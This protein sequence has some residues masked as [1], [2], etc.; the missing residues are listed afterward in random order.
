[1]A[2]IRHAEPK[3]TGDVQS[4]LL[5]SFIGYGVAMGAIFPVFTRYFVDWKPG[6]MGWF[7]ISCLLA[8]VL[9]G[10]LNYRLMNNFLRAR[11]GRIHTVVRAIGEGDFSQRC[12][13]HAHG[14]I[15]EI[16]ASIN[17]MAQR[18]SVSIGEIAQ[19]ALQ[20]SEGAQH[21][22]EIMKTSDTSL[23][24]QRAETAQLSAAINELASSIQQVAV[25][26]TQ[27]AEAAH[28]ANEDTVSGQKIVY[29]T[30]QS[31]NHLAEEVEKTAQ[32]IKRLELDSEKI[33][34]VL[35]V[36][37]SITEQT[38]L[39]ALNAAIEAARAGEHGRGFSV[40]ADEVRTLSK[41]TQESTQEIRHMIEQL[42]SATK[43]AVLVME[44]GRSQAQSSVQHAAQADESLRAIALAVHTIT[45]KSHQIASAAETQNSTAGEVS[46]NSDNIMASSDK[47]AELAEQTST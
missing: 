46:R 42:Q 33:G 7:V 21:L 41:R 3:K 45:E 23:R 8:G 37:R 16:I 20:L 11:L 13:V 2:N 39:L 14:V 34:S 38:N 43:N 35:D 30:I 44:A 17:D 26:A 15:G 36:I 9:V 40:V 32:V 27:A 12:E 25:S 22:S 19:S 29:H 10:Y 4:N 1:M 18:L 47:A 24:H 6:M 31:I 28:Q 5:Y